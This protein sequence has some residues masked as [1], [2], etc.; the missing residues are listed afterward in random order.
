L[1]IVHTQS[2]FI[3]AECWIYSCLFAAVCCAGNS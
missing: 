1:D 3:V 2:L